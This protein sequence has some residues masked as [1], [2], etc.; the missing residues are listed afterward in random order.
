MV[1]NL[2]REV[3][4]MGEKSEI[5]EELSA[6][7]KFKNWLQ[8]N[9]RIILSFLIV[10]T[11]ATG[12]YS[13]SKQRTVSP[14]DNS[15]SEVK[16]A[17]EIGDADKKEEKKEDVQ[18]ASD[19]SAEKTEDKKEDVAKE[20][21]SEDKEKDVV[22]ED[23]SSTT[24]DSG[25]QLDEASKSVEGESEAPVTDTTGEETETSFIEMAGRGDSVTTLARKATKEYLEKNSVS[26]LTKEHK[27]YIEDYI[28][29]HVGH[30]GRVGI[31]TKIEFSKDL[32][33]EAI[34]ASQKL[35]DKQLDHLKIY[36]SR[37]SGL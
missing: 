29:K 24:D 37:V 5:Q 25:V 2:E 4:K 26:D 15:Q 31:G 30:V 19:N 13:Y 36:S 11:I 16:V 34:E 32:I 1:S 3:R 22:V 12:I 21:E 28:R 18:V 10:A 23:G 8:D 20:N 33:R 9:I 7:G 14:E 17:N 35:T 6:G 27:I